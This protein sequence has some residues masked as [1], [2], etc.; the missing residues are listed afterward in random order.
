MREAE[1]AGVGLS[2]ALLQAIN[3]NKAHECAIALTAT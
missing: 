3:Q 2:A 1:T